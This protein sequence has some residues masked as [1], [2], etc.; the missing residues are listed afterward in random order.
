MFRINFNTAWRNM[1]RNK[2]HSSILILG[3]GMGMAVALL[4]GLWVYDQYSFDRFLPGYHQVYQAMLN[5]E[6]NG[7]IIFDN[8]TAIPLA[9]AL[10]K[11]IP[12]ID[13]AAQYDPASHGLMEGD[14]KFYLPGAMAGEDFLRI[15]PF[16][17]QEGNP[18]SLLNDPY[19]IVLTRSTATALFGHKDPLNKRVPLVSQGQYPGRYL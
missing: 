12:E 1:K 8:V 19:S 2:A 3:L 17:M 4:I 10:R 11:D 15:F 14:K 5:S 6:D 7:E 13:F 9:A 18:S 16:P